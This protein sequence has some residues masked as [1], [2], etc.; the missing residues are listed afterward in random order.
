MADKRKDTYNA[1]VNYGIK[2]NQNLGTDITLV[3]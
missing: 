1:N 2:E 3:I